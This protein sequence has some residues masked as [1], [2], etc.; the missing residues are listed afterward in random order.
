M[1][2]YAV[3]IKSCKLQIWLFINVCL[4]L[5]CKD[6]SCHTPSNLLLPL[7]LYQNN[8][9][10]GL[11][12]P[13]SDSADDHATAVQSSQGVYA[14]QYAA[15]PAQVV[16]RHAF[17]SDP[18]NFNVASAS[19][20]N[21]AASRLLPPAP[22]V[23]VPQPPSYI[24]GQLE[25]Y[26]SNFEHGDSQRETEELSSLL[27]P[28]PPP[29]PG[30]GLPS[31]EYKGG[32]LQMHSSVFEHGHHARETE[33]RGEPPYRPYFSAGKTV[34]VANAPVLM[35]PVGPSRFFFYPPGP[36]GQD[37]HMYYY[38]ITGQLPPG[39]YTHA[40]ASHDAG[41]NHF[42]EAHYER[43]GPQPRLMETQEVSSDM[44]MQQSGGGRK[45]Y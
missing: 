11:T 29:P 30:P 25:N 28:P 13:K 38:F 44:G 1:N 23:S 36:L 16:N 22:G 35:A 7:D 26:M 45:G 9:D 14:S 39:T 19:G 43:F 15:D 41:G 20:A 18:T 5:V 12:A 17:G 4:T 32:D 31:E 40:S 24:G 21:Q 8:Y 10:G 37:P 6:L 2:V 34:S 33:E 27:P 42:Q 3:P